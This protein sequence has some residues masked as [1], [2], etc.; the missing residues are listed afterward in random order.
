VFGMDQSVWLAGW[1]AGKEANGGAPGCTS[2]RGAAPCGG[3][4]PPARQQQR[5]T[6][7][8]SGQCSSGRQAALLLLLL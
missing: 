4:R 7:A 1:L 3:C 5:R 2:C 6:G 8:A